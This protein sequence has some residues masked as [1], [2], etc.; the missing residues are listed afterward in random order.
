MTTLPTIKLI[1]FNPL[2][3]DDFDASHSGAVLIDELCASVHRRETHYG[4]ADERLAAATA[5][6]DFCTPSQKREDYL[7]YYGIGE[8]YFAVDKA[9]GNLPIGFVIVQDGEDRTDCY[10]I[11]RYILEGERDKKYGRA[12][13]TKIEGLLLNRGAREVVA[14]SDA[15]NAPS[16][17]SLMSAG[18]KPERPMSTDRLIEFPSATCIAFSKSL[19]PAPQA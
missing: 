3:T 1:P 2:E 8:C 18:F 19:L 17:K 13:L 15:H 11:G 14:V 9:R 12:I 10:E 7:G 4:L 6:L 16:H 5:R